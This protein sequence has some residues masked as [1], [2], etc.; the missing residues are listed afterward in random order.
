[1]T[2]EKTIYIKNLECLAKEIF[3]FLHGLSPPI[4]NDIFEVRCNSDFILLAKKL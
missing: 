2:N 1:M 4:M 3:K